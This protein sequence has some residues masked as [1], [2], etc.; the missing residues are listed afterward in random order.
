MR[1][2]ADLD[3]DGD[4]DVLATS[5]YSDNV[6]WFRNDGAGNFGQLRLIGLVYEPYY[7][8]ATDMNADGLDRCYCFCV[9]G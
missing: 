8:Q 2:A 3:G 1:A 4:L 5:Y 9:R 7:V 6:V